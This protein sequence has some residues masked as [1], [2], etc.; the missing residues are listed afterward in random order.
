M[1]QV[2]AYR[3]A[4]FRN[5]IT[6]SSYREHISEPRQACNRP[7]KVNFLFLCPAH[8][9]QH[10]RFE[11]T[12]M[13]PI[14]EK[15]MF[16]S[17]VRYLVHR[18]YNQLRL[19]PD[20]KTLTVNIDAPLG[21]FAQLNWCLYILAYCEEHNLV[22]GIRLIST[23]YGTDDHRNW[24]LDFFEQREAN[25]SN[26][27]DQ[28][29]ADSENGNVLSIHH[30]CETGFASRYANAMTI[31]RA[32]EL[33]TKNYRIAPC[34]EMH[35]NGFAARELSRGMTIGLHFRGTDKETEAEPVTWS[36]CF[37]SVVRY[38][39]DNPEVKVAF[40]A[41]DDGRFIEWFSRQAN[42]TL[43]VVTHQD[44]ERSKDGL[45]VH[46]NPA[47]NGYRK[48]FEALV[49]CL[50]LS[51]CS[52]LI[53]TASFLSGW[54]SVFNP[55]LPITLLNEPYTHTSWFPDRELIQRSDNRY[56]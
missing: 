6:I 46:V 54:S 23:Q 12:A 10:G 9:V 20:A 25:E 35:V 52:A 28:S 17:S 29:P 15:I 55:K 24:F 13:S 18:A 3:S 14:R 7:H 53:R 37:K 4:V 5:A 33:F 48:G 50:I 8:A 32:H 56:R 19:R 40:I 43:S 34:I 38:V 1:D 22:P 27:I 16:A 26:A 21:F 45:P 44:E 42:G 47:G 49:N 31:E 2:T 39:E 51:R 41:S 11:V 36:R 30:I